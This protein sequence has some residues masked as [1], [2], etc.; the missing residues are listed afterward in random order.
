MCETIRL[1]GDVDDIETVAQLEKHFGVEATP[2]KE[3]YYGDII[4]DACLCQ[5]DL[6]RFMADKT[7]RFYKDWGDWWEI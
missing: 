4:P 7:D 5:I 1:K 6:D 2:L 3:S